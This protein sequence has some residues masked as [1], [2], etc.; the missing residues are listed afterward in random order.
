MRITSGG[1]LIKANQISASDVANS[2]GRVYYL[3]PVHHSHLGLLGSQSLSEASIGRGVVSA[4]SAEIPACCAGT[5]NTRMAFCMCQ[6][7]C[8]CSVI[9]LAS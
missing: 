3:W 5:C 1:S 8:R 4:L 2:T 9:L 6:I 7:R